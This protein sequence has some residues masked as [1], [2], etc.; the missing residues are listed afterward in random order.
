MT[1]RPTLPLVFLMGFLLSGHLFA[2][3]RTIP[4]DIFLMVD[5]SLS[6]AELG[7]FENMSRWV[8]DRFLGQILIE[9][10]WVSIYQFY[11]SC[12][13]VITREISSNYDRQAIL[14]A[15]KAIRPDGRYTDIGLALDTLKDA[16]AR[17]GDSGRYKILL[18]L[19]DLKQDAPWSSRYAGKMD[20]FKSPYLAE[21]RVIEH[22]NWY[23]ITV[24]MDIQDR[25]VKTSRALFNLIESHR[26]MPPI[27]PETSDT[28]SAEGFITQSVQPDQH[29]DI[30]STALKSEYNR[31]E[32]IKLTGE[33]PLGFL[34]IGAGILILASLTV[35][36][37]RV[38]RSRKQENR[39]S[40]STHKAS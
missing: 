38:I 9:G 31:N 7:R 32:D 15:F 18:M 8:T 2:G 36:A 39:D 5:K 30:P 24:D 3:E 26:N 25:V 27:H 11:G 23:E 34:L 37:V 6:M 13:H 40:D 4:V 20:R 14:E 35:L 19:T 33:N 1:K 22:E 16:L 12:E 21:A 28:A 10:D 29:T 17:R